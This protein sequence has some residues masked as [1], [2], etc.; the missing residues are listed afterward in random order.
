MCFTTGVALIRLVRSMSV[1][2]SHFCVTKVA[3][4][5]DIPN[6]FMINFRF[7]PYCER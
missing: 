6:L 7:T 3:T 1:G 2:N 5:A 4:F